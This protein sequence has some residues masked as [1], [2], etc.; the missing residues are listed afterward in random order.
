MIDIDWIEFLTKEF[1]S[2]KI[3]SGRNGKE[4]NID[5]ISE[6]CPN[7]KNHMF[8]NM[9]SNEPKHDK[10][11]ICQRC[12]LQGNH[13]AFLVHYYGLPY[14]E[15]LKN[16]GDLYG[17]EIDTFSDLE[18]WAKII[19]K[20]KINLK[21]KDDKDEKFKIDIPKSIR[22]YHQTE[23]LRNRKI[24]ENL[25]K[26]FKIRIC[27]S[28]LY[29]N[30]LI[31]PV[32]TD[33]NLS[34]C[35]YSQYDKK[36]LKRYKRLHKEY[37]DKKSFELRSKKILNPSKSVH[38]IMLYNYDNI[39]KYIKLLLIHEGIFDCMRTFEYGYHSV[40]IFKSIISEHQARLIDNIH[41][42]E[43]CLMLDSDVKEEVISRNINL[44]KNVCDSTVTCILLKKGD[45]DDI[46]DKYKFIKIIKRR[47]NVSI[48]YN[49]NK[50]L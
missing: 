37:P 27:Y 6:D 50:L 41:A 49:T 33:R 28:G 48:H 46:K 39:P 17:R 45:P 15:I 18:K 16:Y 47:K 32:S 31:F 23:F 20:D 11:F 12:G 1:P 34:F 40:G 9:G 3:I 5:C 42:K 35:A 38:S 43:I 36:T 8:V 30:R 2:K 21:N 4:L 25:I 13:K 19:L 29:K 10:K 44:L 26:K 7:P 14:N 24:S 22:L